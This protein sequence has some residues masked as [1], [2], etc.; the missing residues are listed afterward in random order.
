MCL[1]RI[2][3]LW[4]LQTLNLDP[5]PQK[6]ARLSL[7]FQT[8]PRPT[9]GLTSCTT[10]YPEQVEE[11]TESLTAV[12]FLLSREACVLGGSLPCHCMQIHEV[13]LAHRKVSYN[14]LHSCKFGY[15]NSR[16]R[17]HVWS[18]VNV[19][20]QIWLLTFTSSQ[21]SPD[22]HR[23]ADRGPP[24]SLTSLITCKPPCLG[25][26]H[27]EEEEGEL[28][29]QGSSYLSGRKHSL[30]LSHFRFSF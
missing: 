16:R 9:Q 23:W 19:F 20:L 5:A 14:S 10:G 3:V 8:H 24:P 25:P 30:F 22:L 29:V 26:V 2:G 4:V 12:S 18:V 1:W 7:A 13:F 17:S 21:M 11:V 15:S 28:R 27:L 6:C